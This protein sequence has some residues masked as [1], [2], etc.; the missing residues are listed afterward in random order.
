MGHIILYFT[1]AVLLPLSY[2][3]LGVLVA[4]YYVHRYRASDTAN[5]VTIMPALWA[6]WPMLLAVIGYNKL[7]RR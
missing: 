3:A 5:G 2:V 7:V 6:A 4:G 1:L